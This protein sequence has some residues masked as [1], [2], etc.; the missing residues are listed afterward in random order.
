MDFDRTQIFDRR[1]VQMACHREIAVQSLAP[2]VS[3]AGSHVRDGSADGTGDLG[4]ASDLGTVPSAPHQ[5]PGAVDA[6][7]HWLAGRCRTGDVVSPAGL[8]GSRGKGRTRRPRP[9]YWGMTRSLA[10]ECGR[11]KVTVNAVCPPAG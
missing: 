9:A 11:S 5:D 10:L 3:P 4:S 1:R 6:V 7:R 8:L 2:A